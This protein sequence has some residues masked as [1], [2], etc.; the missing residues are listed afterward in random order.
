M[1][2]KRSPWKRYMARWHMCP[3]IGILWLHKVYPKLA[4]KYLSQLW[5]R[6]GTV[7]H[8][9]WVHFSCPE[10]RNIFVLLRRFCLLFQAMQIL[11]NIGYEKCALH[12]EYEIG[13]GIMATIVAR[14][15]RDNAIDMR[16]YW[17]KYWHVILSSPLSSSFASTT[18]QQ[19]T[20]VGKRKRRQS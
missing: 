17:S 7:L 14:W 9:A 15:N 6:I 1:V 4:Q 19:H 8:A 18:T 3:Y 16:V 20:K 13:I 10:S 2:E 11:A 5:A 12:K